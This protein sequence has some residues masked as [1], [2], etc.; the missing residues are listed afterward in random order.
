MIVL[1]LVVKSGLRNR[2][3]PRKPMFL[4]SCK[5][6]RLV[7]SFTSKTRRI[8]MTH[9]FRRLLL[10][11][12]SLSTSLSLKYLSRSNQRFLSTLVQERKGV[13]SRSC[14]LNIFPENNTGKENIL[15]VNWNLLEPV[16]QSL[17]QTNFSRLLQ[18]LV[19]SYLWWLLL[20][21]IKDDIF[22]IILYTA[23]GIIK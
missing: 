8:S 11:K 12:N 10:I 14:R 19:T 23:H 22:S 7:S 5:S 18:N 2:K 1:W 17:S 3:H 16:Q 20:V 6:N 9:L 4:G 21:R 15:R 13:S